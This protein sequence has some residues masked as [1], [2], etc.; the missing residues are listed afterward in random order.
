MRFLKNLMVMLLLLTLANPI[1]VQAE[2]SLIPNAKSGLLMEAATGTIIYE[3]NIHE[4]VSVASM[5]KMMGMILIMEA[6]EDGSISLE[7]KVTVSKNAS[8]MGGSQIW[9]EE[10]E[11]ITVLDL[12]KGI[13]MASA[14]DGIVCMAERIAGT[15]ADFVKM[16]NAKAKELGLKNTNFVNP[17]GLDEENHYS[18]AYDMAIIARELIKHEEI[19][20]YTSVYEDYLRKG[21]NREYWLVNTNKLIKTYQGADGLKTGFT[22]DALYCMAVTAKRNNMRLIAIVLGE[23]EGKVRNQ[24]TAELLDYGFNLYEVTTIKKKGDVLGNITI[25][26]ADTEEIEIVALRDVTVLKKQSDKDKEYKSEVRL[27]DLNLPIQKNEVIGSLIVK[28]DLGNKIDEVEITVLTDIKK[29]NFLKIFLKVLK[30][31]II[32]ELF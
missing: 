4:K 28:D 30:S 16:M 3:K 14:N 20:N 32:G 17:T 21:T 24:E 19:F 31:M 7:E 6:L 12:I 8:G 26:K 13:M 27:N 23:E 9:L 5:T 29:D 10:G 18:S 2:E 1:F 15:E 11:Q 25:D 22:D